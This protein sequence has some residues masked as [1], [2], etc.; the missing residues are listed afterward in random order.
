[1][2]KTKQ[3]EKKKKMIKKGVKPNTWPNNSRPSTHRPRGEE[4]MGLEARAALLALCN[5]FSYLDNE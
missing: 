5:F 1:M 3:K 4:R 2:P